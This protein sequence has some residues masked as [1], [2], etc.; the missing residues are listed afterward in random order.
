MHRQPGEC[1]GKYGN[2]KY[3]PSDLHCKAPIRIVEELV[4]H[5]F[6]VGNTGGVGDVL[7]LEVSGQFGQGFLIFGRETIQVAGSAFL[8]GF[9]DI[10]PVGK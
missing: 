2:Y 1:Y 10:Y 7:R 4:L 8:G 9:F 5:A 3:D 6:V